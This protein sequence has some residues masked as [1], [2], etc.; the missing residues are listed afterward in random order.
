MSDTP[1]YT[2]I[3]DYMSCVLIDVQPKTPILTRTLQKKLAQ[4][5][6]CAHLCAKA[7]ITKL[8]SVHVDDAKD[9]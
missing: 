4:N 3:S 6:D 2:Y 7:A 5:N 9:A 1:I 8:T